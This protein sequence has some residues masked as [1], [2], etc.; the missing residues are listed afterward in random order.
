MMVDETNIDWLRA[1]RI[2]LAASV[3]LHLGWEALHLPLYTIWY[4]G[5]ARDMAFAVAH[6]TAGD[7]IIASLSLMAALVLV[8]DRAWPLRQFMPVVLV[9]LVLGMGYTVYSEWLNTVVRKSWSYSA[10]MPTLPWIGTGLSP[11]LQWLF[12]PAVGFAALR[13][14]GRSLA[15]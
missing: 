4:T 9:S 8:G 10:S 11:L 2:Y 12:V 15:R 13:Q 5:R 1:F 7:V 3:V 6:C 14:N